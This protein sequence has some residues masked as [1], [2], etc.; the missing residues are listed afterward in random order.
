[1][2]RQFALIFTLILFATAFLIQGC[3]IPSKQEIEN[4]KGEIGKLRGEI[5]ALKES[6]ESQKRSINSLESSL[7]ISREQMGKIRRLESRLNCFESAEYDLPV[8]EYK[9]VNVHNGFFLASVK[10]A[11]QYGNSVKLTLE[12][13]NFVLSEFRGF[14]IKAKWGQKEPAKNPN[15]DWETF[16]RKHKYWES[17]LSAKEFGFSE[18]SKGG[19]WTNIELLLPDTRIAELGYL[20]FLIETTTVRMRGN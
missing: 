1:M 9:R 7:E 3:D 19:T 15:E 13:G 2:K 5:D 11:S 6:M 4:L 17:S 8:N 12:I 10:E 14:K 16:L 18:A 20:N